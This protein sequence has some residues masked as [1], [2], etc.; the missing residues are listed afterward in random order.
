MQWLGRQ[1]ALV[2]YLPNFVDVEVRIRLLEND[3]YLTFLSKQQQTR[4]NNLEWKGDASLY[5]L[6]LTSGVGFQIITS[7]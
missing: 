4:K 7:F 3:V 2:N 6:L 1:S 5:I